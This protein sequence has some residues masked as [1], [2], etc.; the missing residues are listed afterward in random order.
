[1]AV[2][3]LDQ[4]NEPRPLIARPASSYFLRSITGDLGNKKSR[5]HLQS[6]NLFWSDIRVSDGEFGF[7]RH[8]ARNAHI[9][10]PQR[11]HDAPIDRIMLL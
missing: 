2:G 11:S 7:G 10:P 9:M 1:M 4:N 6:M 8:D 5:F 3:L